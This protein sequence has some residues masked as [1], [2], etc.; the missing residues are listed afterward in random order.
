MIGSM[1]GRVLGDENRF[2]LALMDSTNIRMETQAQR[3]IHG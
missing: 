2:R 1:L 3:T